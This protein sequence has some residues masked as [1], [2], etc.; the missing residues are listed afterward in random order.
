VEFEITWGGDPEDASVTTWGTA[1]AE[2]L[3]AWV[4]EAL[5]D[6]RFH[7]KMHFLIDH[8]QLDWS[9]LSPNDVHKRVELFA[10][11]A[12]HLDSARIAVVMGALVDFGIARMEQAYVELDPDLK[13]KIRVFFS[14]EDAREWLRERTAADASSVG[15]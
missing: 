9:D 13:I 14:I 12:V 7:A 3:D 4:Q 2:G 5:S 6:S 1:T 10:R 11:N 15:S 8:R